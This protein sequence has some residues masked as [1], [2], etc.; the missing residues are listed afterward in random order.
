M[1]S[2]DAPSSSDD[3]D[4]VVVG[5]DDVSNYNPDNILPES[6]DTIA[7]IRQWLRPTEYSLDGSEYRKHLASHLANTGE[8]LPRL[9]RYKTWHDSPDHGL[10]WIRGVPGSGKS[11]I[12]ATLAHRLSQEDVPVLYFFFRQIIDA[13]HRPINLLRDWLDQILLYSPPLQ[14]TLKEYIDTDRSLDSVSM[15]EL[16]RHLR[17]ALASIPLTYCVVDA[18]DEMDQ[19]NDGFVRSLADLGHWRPSSVKVLMTSRPVVSV[20]TPM[21]G[22]GCIDIRMEEDLID[23]DIA[24][25]VRHCLDGTSISEDDRQ[26]IKQAVPGRA[27]GLFLYA[28]LAMKAFLEPN[29]DVST[30]LE[31]LPLDMEAMY[32][33]LLQEHARRSGISETTQVLILRW[34]THSTRPLRLL[35]LADML[36]YVLGGQSTSLKDNKDLVRAACGPLLEILPDE[37]VSVVHHS[38]TEF[39][40]GTKR[41]VH[42]A[43]PVLDPISSHSQLAE[44]CLKYL[45]SGCLQCTSPDSKRFNQNLMNLNFPFTEYAIDNWNVHV[46]RSEWNGLP[47]NLI[48]QQLE[49]FLSD[50]ST[51]NTWLRMYL[52]ES[53]GLIDDEYLSSFSDLHVAA[54]CGLDSYITTLIDQNNQAKIDQEDLQERTPL[55]WA[56][57]R[58]HA[59]AV[60]VLLQAGAAPNQPDL[61]GQKPLHK[62]AMFDRFEVVQLLLEEGV[63]PLTKKGRDYTSSGMKSHSRLLTPVEIACSHGHLRSVEAFLPFID[64]DTKQLALSWAAGGAQSH[65]LKRLLQEPG[66]DPNARH[67]DETP[68]SAAAAMGNVDAMEV[69][70]DAGADASITSKAHAWDEPMIGHVELWWTPLASFCRRQ[71]HVPA[72]R[73]YQRHGHYQPGKNA[74]KT[75]RTDDFR[76]GL[77]LLVRAGA[78]VNERDSFGRTGIHVTSDPEVVRILLD[79]G[80]DP[81]AETRLGETVLHS[82]PRGADENYLKLLVEDGG[83]DINKREFRMGQTPLMS[84]IVRDLDIAVRILDYGPDLNAVDNAGNG[85]LHYAVSQYSKP[86]FDEP[87]VENE[88]SKKSRRLHIL[89]SALLEAGADPSLANEEGQTPLHMFDVRSLLHC[90]ELI[91]LLVK[92]GASTEDRDSMGYTPLFRQIGRAQDLLEQHRLIKVF[93][94]ASA[95][96]HARDNRGR[97][98]LHEVIRY[99]DKLN[100]GKCSLT[101]AFQELIDA[102][103]SPFIVDFQ[104]NTLC[105]ELVKG[106]NPSYASDF[107]AA[108][109]PLF[110]KLGLDTDQPDFEGR[111]PLHLACML[112]FPDDPG[113]RGE[114]VARCAEWFLDHSSNPN[115]EDKQG[116]RPIHLAAS[117]SDY[118]VDQL[119]RAGADPFA[120][121][122]QGLNALSIASRCRLSNTLGLV[123]ERMKDLDPQAMLKA[124]N[125]K[126]IS[127]LTPLHYASRSGRIESVSLLLEAGADVNPTFDASLL[128]EH[129]EPWYPPVLQCVFFKQ[130]NALWRQDDTLRVSGGYS[131]PLSIRSRF[132]ND[133]RDRPASVA[134]TIEDTNRPRQR[135]PSRHPPSKVFDA[136]LSIVRYDEIVKTLLSAGAKMYDNSHW[137]HSALYSAMRFAAREWDDYVVNLLWTYHEEIEGPELPEPIK[138]AV[139]MSRA[140]RQMDTKLLGE[141]ILPCSKEVTWETIEE[142]LSDREYSLILKLREAGADFLSASSSGQSIL[143]EFVKLGFAQ[144]VDGCCSSE[145][146]LRFDDPEWRQEQEGHPSADPFEPLA[147]TACLRAAPNMDVLQVLVEKKGVDINAP[148]TIDRTGMRAL[149]AV[150]EGGSWWQVAQAMPYLVSK[151]ADLEARDYKGN[152]PLHC[153]LAKYNRFHVVAAKTLIELG[154]DVNAVDSAGEGCLEKAA[155]SQELVRLLVNHG[156]EVSPAAISSAARNKDLGVMKALLSS[157]KTPAL[158]KCW[159]LGLNDVRGLDPSSPEARI[160]RQ[161]HPLYV[162]GTIL[163]SRRTSEDDDVGEMRARKMMEALLEAG[164]S[165]YDTLLIQSDFRDGSSRPSLPMTVANRRWRREDKESEKIPFLEDSEDGLAP[166]LLA[167]RLVFHQL[168]ADHSIYEP[169]LKLPGL[170]LE[171]RNASGQTPLLA[172]CR[173]GAAASPL[174]YK[175]VLKDLL[176]RGADPTV[177]DGYGRNCLHHCLNRHSAIV[178]M[179]QL[180]ELGDAV[181]ALVNQPD[182]YGY[183]PM[184]YRLAALAQGVLGPQTDEWLDYLIAQGMDVTATDGDGN[185]ALH[186]LASSLSPSSSQLDAG[187]RLFKR[188]V[189]FGLDVNARNKAGQTPVFFLH[190][191]GVVFGQES[192]VLEMLDE[193]GVDW[194]VRDDKGKTVLHG[195]AVECDR[196]F[197]GIMDRG[198]DPLLEDADGRTSL[199]LATAYGN[200]GVMRLFDKKN[201]GD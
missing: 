168:L 48:S 99:G 177:L 189:E 6:E 90:P 188:F 148:S 42:S 37:T 81:N 30:A 179:K 8:W 53:H 80:A 64:A 144:L 138:V 82:L 73:F 164:V 106:P 132:D 46:A 103:V 100:R 98:L 2:H 197:K 55:W 28:K 129:A 70:I 40:T 10:L 89:L 156:V 88:E 183:H 72:L 78:D 1:A 147:I 96:L 167:D 175:P 200:V 169:I 77:S 173:G 184:H 21:R 67:L 54:I 134:F 26:R 27:N 19:Y 18:L 13:S 119:I 116:V 115:A 122:N 141:A 150:A 182:T 178:V 25:Y 16:W 172:A 23:I 101:S 109:W 104:G 87:F 142:L 140:R 137:D 191:R 170:D 131:N 152:T 86:L 174:Y 198:V 113:D 34:V 85:P 60:R 128:S 31:M 151:G 41:P 123:L 45:Q 92:F 94:K 118:A 35:E 52:Q 69:L 4:V 61:G 56:A 127:Q 29:V 161:G 192:D 65:I 9:D 59:G 125:A 193:M 153:A 38:L 171:R 24:T 11:V 36:K 14:A 181:P 12:A 50:D 74:P 49:S 58:G 201:E 95:R 121:T 83:A 20:E 160:A 63:D 165:P 5:R 176:D 75:N 124:V 166:A 97:T 157:K 66:I 47:G 105:H 185:G 143:Q 15:D 199:D 22:I 186:F 62:A 155:H 133:D 110:E 107:L 146:A 180:Q 93:R 196:F 7:K 17:M 126:D 135:E 136:D 111:T 39:L 117:T 84:A 159:N 79:A 158:V 108:F 120:S 91:K 71:N 112:N 33:N 163:P 57:D 187:R 68:L 44:V 51:K 149:H 32:V 145:E 194:L 43:Y 154:A 162:A 114:H 102:G 190:S 139:T 76:R 195:V 130:E 3:N